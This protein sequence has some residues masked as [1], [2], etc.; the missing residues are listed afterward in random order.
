MCDMAEPKRDITDD[1]AETTAGCIGAIIAGP[2]GIVATVLA[3]A[4]LYDRNKVRLQ[5]TF[6]SASVTVKR[7]HC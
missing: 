6:S 1:M 3:G 2:F 4:F 5:E 7:N